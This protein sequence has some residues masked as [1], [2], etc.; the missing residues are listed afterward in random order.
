[1]LSRTA[2]YALRAVVHLAAR[3]GEARTAQQ[4]AE[5]TGVPA[6]YLAKILQRLVRA[7]LVGSQR[8]LRGGFTLLREPRDLSLLDV[9]T[10]VDPVRRI[11][12][13]P[14]GRGGHGENLCPLHRRLDQALAGVE[15]VLAA[16]RVSELL[17]G[18][19]TAVGALCAPGDE[20]DPS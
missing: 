11:R 12:T 2:E 19:G 14:L 7:G 5:A 8:G 20:P 15:E 6:G 13:C 16:A 9:V 4:I 3:P 17:D 18:H 10:V 1:M